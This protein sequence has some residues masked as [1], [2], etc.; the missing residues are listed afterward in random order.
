MFFLNGHVE[1]CAFKTFV[2]KVHCENKNN[3]K[4]DNAQNNKGFMFRMNSGRE[5]VAQENFYIKHLF[6]PISQFARIVFTDTS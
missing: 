6:T 4:N 5:N 1:P 3:T 2:L